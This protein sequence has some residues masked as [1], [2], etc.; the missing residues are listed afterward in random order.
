MAR[1]AAG[2]IRWSS[3]VHPVYRY[4]LAFRGL[5]FGESDTEYPYSRRQWL[6]AQPRTVWRRPSGLIRSIQIPTELF[7]PPSA[8]LSLRSSDLWAPGTEEHLPSVPYFA[9]L[10]L[11]VVRVPA[12]S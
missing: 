7:P 6:W 11:R 10:A 5:H 8:R 1:I 2:R 12:S 9:R 4:S 3:L